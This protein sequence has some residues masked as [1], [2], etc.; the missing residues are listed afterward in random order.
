MVLRQKGF[1]LLEISIAMIIVAALAVITAQS[2]S[3]KIN[4][5]YIEQTAAEVWAVGEYA[6]GYIARYNK[7]PGE[8]GNCVD[9]LTEIQNMSVN[10][11]TES[12]WGTPYI[13]NCISN[14]SFT[15]TVQTDDVWAPVLTNMLA[16][17]QMVGGTTDTTITTLP[18]P[19]SIAALDDVLKKVDTGDVIDNT[20]ETD[21]YMNDGTHSHSIRGA[22]QV[23]ASEFVDADNDSF[24]LDPNDDSNI[25][26]LVVNGIL[27]SESA[28]YATSGMLD[29]GKGGSHPGYAAAFRGRNGDGDHEWTTEPE[30]FNGSIN[31]ND[32]MLRSVGHWLSARLPDMVEK[33]SFVAYGGDLIPKPDCPA[34]EN[35]SFPDPVQMVKVHPAE[36]N[37]ARD[38]DDDYWEVVADDGLQELHADVYCYYQPLNDPFNG[39]TQIAIGDLAQQLIDDGHIVAN[40]LAGSFAFDGA[41]RFENDTNGFIY[42]APYF[43]RDSWHRPAYFTYDTRTYVMP[44]VAD[45][46]ISADFYVSDASNLVYADNIHNDMWLKLQI[47]VSYSCNTDDDYYH[48]LN[49]NGAS[50][51]QQF[52]P[53]CYGSR[54]VPFTV[55]V[56]PSEDVTVYLETNFPNGDEGSGSDHLHITSTTVT[57]SLYF[58]DPAP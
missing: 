32:I 40:N 52:F 29:D 48:R 22:D 23:E 13:T 43:P 11:P 58:S 36:G 30:S 34:V 38:Y 47:N 12:P 51:N 53:N 46:T 56:D 17:T 18:L 15:V 5:T 20:M 50:S 35:S 54:T 19:G 24:V 39:N 7:W 4:Q 2:V 16:V 1:T 33:R 27:F 41:A 21:L 37:Y 55:I 3:R 8:D 10:V 31:V 6:Q 44:V 14:V 25:N 42:P 28:L 49:I 45:E 9:A 57:S 26:T